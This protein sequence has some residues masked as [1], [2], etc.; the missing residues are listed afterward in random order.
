MRCSWKHP[1]RGETN[2]GEFSSYSTGTNFPINIRKALEG[3]YTGGQIPKHSMQKKKTI[4]VWYCSARKTPVVKWRRYRRNM[5]TSTE[6]NGEDTITSLMLLEMIA[7]TNWEQTCKNPTRASEKLTNWQ[8]SSYRKQFRH[9]P[10]KVSI[11][12]N[13]SDGCERYLVCPDTPHF[14]LNHVGYLWTTNNYGRGNPSFWH[15]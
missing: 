1:L 10:Q 4:W 7:Y 11:N 6:M 8:S 12:R 5:R 15:L 2:S 13:P 14:A 9:L 3:W